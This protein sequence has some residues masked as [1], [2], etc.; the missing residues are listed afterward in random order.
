VKPPG[1]GP[2]GS[3]EAVAG[4]MEFKVVDEHN[5]YYRPYRRTDFTHDSWRDQ[6]GLSPG[7]PMPRTRRP[8]RLAAFG[9]MVHRDEQGWY[10]FDYRRTELRRAG[11]FINRTT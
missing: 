1:K 7:C 6:S 11:D 3:L 4:V 8:G 5:E 9:D 10:S 2:I